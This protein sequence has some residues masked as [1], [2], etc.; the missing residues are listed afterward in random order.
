ME[1][2]VVVAGGLAPWCATSALA[3]LLLVLLRKA[4]PPEFLCRS[5]GLDALGKGVR[6]RRVV[7][8]RRQQKVGPGRRPLASKCPAEI[9]YEHQ[10]S[11][12]RQS[13]ERSVAVIPVGRPQHAG[14]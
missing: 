4:H 8:A 14:E 5:F 7:E 2:A 11:P 6:A 13:M 12:E 9:L 10:M 1:V 3:E